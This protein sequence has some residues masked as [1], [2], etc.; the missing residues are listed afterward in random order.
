MT[1]LMLLPAMPRQQNDVG[2]Y[3]GDRMIDS[4]RPRKLAR[5]RMFHARLAVMPLSGSACTPPPPSYNKTNLFGETV[6]WSKLWFYA[7]FG[8]VQIHTYYYWY[9]ITHLLFLSRLNTFLFSK[10]FP[11]QPFLF[12]LQVSLYGFPQTSYCYFLP[13][14]YFTF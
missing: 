12:F 2:L 7:N 4:H 14:P 3:I 8:I 13:Y 5:S 9:S 6:E 11:S 1:S 10:S